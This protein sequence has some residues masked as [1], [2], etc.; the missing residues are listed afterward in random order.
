MQA[1]G[2]ASGLSP[3]AIFTMSSNEFRRCCDPMKEVRLISAIADAAL[4]P[5]SKLILSSTDEPMFS[6]VGFLTV[7]L[8]VKK[9]GRNRFRDA[10]TPPPE[11]P[12]GRVEKVGAEEQ[13]VVVVPTPGS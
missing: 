9:L 2:M 11:S 7:F 1:V 4:G 13:A 5:V 10:G 12:G 8:S 3:S 6:K